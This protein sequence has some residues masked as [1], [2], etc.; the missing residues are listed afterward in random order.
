MNPFNKKQRTV[1]NN[2]MDVLKAQM[3]IDILKDQLA[4][5]D[6]QIIKCYEYALAN[7]ELPYNLE[8]LCQN[9]Q[10]IRSRINELQGGEE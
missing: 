9:R 2:A 5:S 4:Q 1:Q 6:Y 8:E 3:Q 7:K 10:A